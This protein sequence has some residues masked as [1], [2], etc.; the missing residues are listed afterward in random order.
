MAR[1]TTTPLGT[2]SVAA[3]RWL[4]VG[5]PYD[6]T[7]TATRAAAAV[8]ATAAPAR[9]EKRLAVAHRGIATG[10]GW[11]ALHFSGTIIG[12]FAALGTA[13]AVFG[14]LN[15]AAIWAGAWFKRG[16]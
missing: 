13:L 6:M 3:T 16:T 9:T 7:E 1:A 4:A 5:L 8:D 2:K 11:L 10:G 12:V 14:L 15:A